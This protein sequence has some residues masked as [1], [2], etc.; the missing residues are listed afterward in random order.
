M[1]RQK[2]L[3]CPVHTTPSKITQLRRSEIILR[4]AGSII[5]VTRRKTRY[6]FPQYCDITNRTVQ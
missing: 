5:F 2:H 6:C 3:I 4:L 1:R